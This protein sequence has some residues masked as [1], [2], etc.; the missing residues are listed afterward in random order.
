MSKT[1]LKNFLH[2]STLLQSDD[3]SAEE[4]VE[5]IKER[6]KEWEKFIGG[7][8]NDNLNWLIYRGMRVR[9]SP[10]ICVKYP[11]E[12]RRPLTTEPKVQ[13]LADSYFKHRFGIKFRAESIFASRSKDL[14]K[15]YGD[16]YAIFP[17]DRVNFAWSPKV[18]DF[19]Y[20]AHYFNTMLKGKD[21]VTDYEFKRFE[22]FMDD[23]EYCHNDDSLVKEFIKFRD[24]K[25]HEIMIK[26][27]EYIAVR[28]NAIP[29]VLD[30]LLA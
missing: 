14:A 22:E 7:Y 28:E 2:E 3:I 11:R 12:N 30:L 25:Q 9:F 17:L 5:M 16:V 4:A 1:T 27:D 21:E 13:E 19:T 8:K 29:K 18:E 23:K 15:A 6:G 10:D 24:Y 26:C 20:E